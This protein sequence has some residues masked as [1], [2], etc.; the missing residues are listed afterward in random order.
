MERTYPRTGEPCNTTLLELAGEGDT[1][2]W[3]QLVD[4]FSPLVW[5]VAR[6]QG[7][8][9]M[10]AADVYQT[11]W[12]RLVEHLGR[13]RDPAAV[14]GWLVATARHEAIRVSR[15]GARERPVEDHGLDQS[16]TDLDTPEAA[17]LLSE[18]HRGVLRA[19]V[20]LSDRCQR[21]LRV[22]S[23]S[24]TT[25]YAEVAAELD[26]PVGSLGPTR[27]RCLKHL[28]QLLEGDDDER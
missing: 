8:G 23:A 3:R 6:A 25:S 28:R 16:A 26:M 4:R 5:S 14:G 17:L 9:R 24:P 19:F 22:L 10:D 20:Q 7:L 18:E 27:G 1:E 11:T 13:L 2:A 15:R 12:L 21:L